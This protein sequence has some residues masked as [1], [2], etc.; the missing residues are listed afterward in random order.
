MFKGA[1]TALATP[2][3][4]GEVD[5]PALRDLIEWQIQSGIDGLFPCGSTGESA[6]LTHAEHDNVVRL[7]IEQARKRV[8][9]LAGTGSNSTAEA[10]RLTT[11][12]REMGADGAVLLSPYYNKPTQDGIFRHYKMIAA[13]VDLP[14]FVYN[15]PGR[16][17]SNIAPETFARLSEIKSI[18]GIKEASGS[19]DQTSDIL[20]LCG[21]RLAIFSGDDALTVPLIALGAKG[22]MST[23]SNV[24]PREMHDLATAALAGDFAKAR[25]IHYRLLPLIRALFVETNPI[26]VKQALAFM[27]KCA[28]ELRMPLVP[29]TVGPAEK[30]RIA[31]KELRLV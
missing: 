3:R 8:P 25:E 27:G 11:A 2:F 21:D 23:C 20:K 15:I 17:A 19:M 7:T 12:A 24:V 10:I 5:A 4:D 26:P 16:T 30:L 29:M 1:L 31:M 14:L 9:V 22:V 18:V 28:N 6:T 13:S